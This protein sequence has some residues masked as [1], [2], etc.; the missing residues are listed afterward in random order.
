MTGGLRAFLRA[1][2]LF[3]RP[4]KA[5]SSSE[6]TRLNRNLR[7][8]D[9]AL[10]SLPKRIPPMHEREGTRP[11]VVVGILPGKTRFL[12][13]IV[14]PL[15]TQIGEW[16]DVNPTVYPVLPAGAG[17]ITQRSVVLLDQVLAVDARR[18]RQYIGRLSEQEYV[19]IQAGI[20]QIFE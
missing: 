4:I 16:V 2:L 6:Q 1:F 19:P 13:A 20:I 3:A 7:K 18:L 8:G 5:L 17:N 15:T 12:L 9:I 14:A 11:V 10:A